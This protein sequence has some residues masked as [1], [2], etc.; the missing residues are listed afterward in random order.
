MISIKIHRAFFTTSY[1]T[2]PVI[3]TGWKISHHLQIYILFD[4]KNMGRK[5]YKTSTYNRNLRVSI[6]LAVLLLFR[7]K[8]RHCLFGANY[9][10]RG[11]GKSKYIIL[12]KGTIN[13]YM[14]CQDLIWNSILLPKLLWPS[15]RKKPE[16]MNNLGI[17]T[18]R[19]QNNFENRT[20]F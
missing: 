4:L 13:K 18:V 5:I 15:V 17:Q 8:L 10:N 7:A 6:Y 11:A 14:L 20:L 9:N 19:V 12:M 1:A 2:L 16:M 3:R